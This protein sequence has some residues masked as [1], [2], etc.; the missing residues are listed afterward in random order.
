LVVPAAAGPLGA[1]ARAQVQ[2]PITYVSA[3]N[4]IARNSKSTLGATRR[5]DRWPHYLPQPVTQLIPTFYNWFNIGTIGSNTGQAI[6]VIEASLEYRGKVVRLTHG[7][8]SSWT[9]ADG[10]NDIEADPVPATAFGLSRIPAGA[11]LWTKTIIASAN[12]K[13]PFATIDTGD[14]AGSQTVVYNDATTTASS[15]TIPGG[16]T[17]SGGTPTVGNYGYRPLMLGRLAAPARVYAVLGDSITEGVG[18][19]RSS[20]WGRGWFQRAMEDNA[21]PSINFGVAGSSSPLGVSNPRVTTLLGYANRG[22]IFYGT[23][24]IGTSGTGATA[25]TITT[26]LKRR[27][28]QMQS[29][30]ISVIGAVKLL[31]RGSSTDSY[32]TAAGQTSYPGWGPGQTS[33]QVNAALGSIGF[34]FVVPAASVR[35]ANPV[36]WKT[37]GTAFYP[38]GDGSHPSATFHGFL[39]AEAAP[40]L[41]N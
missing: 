18:D 41:A 36:L 11:T 17:F 6:T 40:L 3:D 9:V 5:A 13:I 27:I 4:L 24:D 19:T 21:T 37:N 29:A 33:T 34:A 2:Q 30:G 28:S 26:S 12:A 25:A 15:V 8:A 1:P 23:N 16:F 39:G 31:P 32:A 35:D 22:V 7:G 14:V 20:V 10:A 38:T